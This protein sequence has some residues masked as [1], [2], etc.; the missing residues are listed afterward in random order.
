MSSIQWRKVQ[1]AGAVEYT[2]FI[3][4][5]GQDTC[6]NKCLAYD[7]KQSGAVGNVEFPFLTITPRLT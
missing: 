6:I 2:D 3:S 1:S 5:D 4:A 7:A